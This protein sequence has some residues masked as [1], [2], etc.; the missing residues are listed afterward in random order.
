MS[1]ERQMKKI[2]IALISVV[3]LLCGGILIFLKFSEDNVA[4]KITYKDETLEYVKGSSYKT[5]LKG[6][7]AKDNKDG[8]VTGALIVEGIYPNGDGDTATVVYVA[9]DKSNN[10]AKTRRVVSYLEEKK[11][12]LTPVLKEEPL[13][14]TEKD[15]EDPKKEELP[16]SNPRI[17][18]KKKEVKIKKGEDINRISLVESVTDDKD[19]QN[20]LWRSINIRGDGFDKNTAGVYEQIYYVVDSDGNKSNEETLKI[21]VE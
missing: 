13:E 14:E 20:L 15:K 4:P 5:I 19:E 3:S 18:L 10:I 7:K 2:I 21:I 8:D 17:T 16:A 1:G 6:V 12:E 9:R 11:K